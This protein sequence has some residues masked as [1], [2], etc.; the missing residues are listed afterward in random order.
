VEVSAGEYP[1]GHIK[2]PSRQHYG[3]EGIPYV[4]GH[5]FAFSSMAIRRSL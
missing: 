3:K 5:D 4:F 1:T 2:K